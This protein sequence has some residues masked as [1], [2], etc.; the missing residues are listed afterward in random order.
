MEKPL[1]SEVSWERRQGHVDGRERGPERPTPTPLGAPCAVPGQ[2]LHPG[3][4]HQREPL[5]H[6]G[7]DWG[8]SF[9]TPGAAS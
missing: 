4:R 2:T 5:L 7:E 1:P 9:V 8:G 3:H 6:W